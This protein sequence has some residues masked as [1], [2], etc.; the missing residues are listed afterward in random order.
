MRTVDPT[1]E[2]P[3]LPKPPTGPPGVERLKER[4]RAYVDPETGKENL[5]YAQLM[6]EPE[7][8]E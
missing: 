8:E 6:A 7:D 1:A 4:A 5:T 3:E 2:V